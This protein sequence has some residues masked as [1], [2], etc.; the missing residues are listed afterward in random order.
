MSHRVNFSGRTVQPLG[1]NCFQSTTFLILP[2]RRVSS[3]YRNGISIGRALKSLVKFFIRTI[4][5]SCSFHPTPF[6]FNMLLE[7]RIPGYFSRIVRLLMP[8]TQYFSEQYIMRIPVKPLFALRSTFNVAL[9]LVEPPFLFSVDRKVLPSRS[10]ILSRL[11]TAVDLIPYVHRR[12]H[13]DE[14][15]KQTGEDGGVEILRT[16][17]ATEVLWARPK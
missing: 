15:T 17:R 12:M 13:S 5:S 8:V 3:V 7:F 9:L 16:S 2:S 10:V 11:Q 1:G 4:H 14:Q 6:Y